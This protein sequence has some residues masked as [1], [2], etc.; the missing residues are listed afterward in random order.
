VETQNIFNA[1]DGHI[2]GLYYDISPGITGFTSLGTTC[3]PHG[4]P[5]GRVPDRPIPHIIRHSDM[6]DYLN[7]SPFGSFASQASLENVRALKACY[8]GSRCKGMLLIYNDD[9]RSILGQ[10]YE[11][12]HTQPD[13][14]VIPF[15]RGSVLR[16]CFA[17]NGDIQFLSGV[18]SFSEYS[19]LRTSD[20]SVDVVY[21]VST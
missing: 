10:W 2:L 11:S 13:I 15:Q 4:S 9:T 3:R 21:G 12:T 5:L 18:K 8:S 16:F 17:Q 14:Q 6:I 7:A 19:L 20:M 1:R